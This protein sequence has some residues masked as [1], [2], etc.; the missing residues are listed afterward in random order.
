LGRCDR[1][2]FLSN[3]VPCGVLLSALAVGF[4]AVSDFGCRLKRP[5]P[6]PKIA[7]PKLRPP[8][9]RVK[10]MGP[11]DTIPI[12]VAGGFYIS[13]HTGKKILQGQSLPLTQAGLHGTDVEIGSR[14]LP[15]QDYLDVVPEGKGTVEVDHRRYWGSLRLH[16]VGDGK[17]LAV[18]HVDVEHYLMGVLAAEL[19]RRFLGETYKAQAIAART[20]ALYEKYSRRGSNRHYDVLATEGSQV[21]LGL[22]A[23][24]ARAA[25]AVEKT[26]G[27]VLIGATRAGWKIFPTYFSS[28][29]G[30][31]TQPGKY[32]ARVDPNL[33]PLQGNV[34]CT[35]CNISPRY[36]WPQRAVPS[37][38][39]TRRL[40]ERMGLDYQQITQIRVTKRTRYD[41]IAEVELVDASGATITL[42][43]EKFR[44]I[45][46]SRKMAST[47]CKIR[48]E[49]EDF[50][51]YDGHGLGHGVGLCQYGAEGMARKGHTALEILLHYYPHARLVRAY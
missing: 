19:P 47:W 11:A 49:G 40:N 15:I 39:I 27:I 4:V 43:G 7:A 9:I 6:K 35:T 50:V 32:L 16:R 37:A 5:V 44:L 12:A 10:L 28:T 33:R 34:R 51:F 38:E 17:L 21:Y 20:Y 41:R 3:M 30:G 46:G 25:E 1:T 45:V 29:C 48:K 13:D 36:R 18:N 31:R 23:W 42:P 24:T 26:R 14:R 2:K 8:V 22:A